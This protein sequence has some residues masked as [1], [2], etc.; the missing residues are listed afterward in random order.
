[1]DSPTASHGCSKPAECL[2]AAAATLGGLRTVRLR[3]Y[4]CTDYFL[5]AVYPKQWPLTDP[6]AAAAAGFVP[7]TRRAICCSYL[8]NSCITTFGKAHCIQEL[9][10]SSC[11]GDAYGLI[12]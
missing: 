4:Y 2:A 9:H 6:A 11:G 10:S 5:R 3:F 12:A 1:V 7:I 8:V